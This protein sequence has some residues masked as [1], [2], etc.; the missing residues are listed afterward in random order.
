M[1]SKIIESVNL[2]PIKE[3]KKKEN[4]EKTTRSLQ[5]FDPSIRDNI[6]QLLQN[7]KV[8]TFHPQRFPSRNSSKSPKVTAN[9]QATPPPRRTRKPAHPGSSHGKHSRSYPEKCHAYDLIVNN[10][11]SHFERPPRIRIHTTLVDPV[12]GRCW[13]VL[14]GRFPFC[15]QITAQRCGPHS[16]NDLAARIDRSIEKAL[17]KAL[18]KK[19]N[20][21]VARMTSDIRFRARQNEQ[22]SRPTAI[23]PARSFPFHAL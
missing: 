20:A 10:A 1:K 7:S 6:V 2:S 15:P 5:T 9:N 12:S 3:K 17:E 18:G 21:A 22:V 8:R 19:I 4:Q 16:T 13:P 23:H 11:S 14:V